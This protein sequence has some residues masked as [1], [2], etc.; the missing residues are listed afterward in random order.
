[1]HPRFKPLDLNV[2]DAMDQHKSNLDVFDQ[3]NGKSAR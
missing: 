3:S 2:R 1:M